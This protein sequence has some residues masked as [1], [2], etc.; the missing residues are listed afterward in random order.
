MSLLLD[1]ASNSIKRS[2]IIEFIFKLALCFEFLG[3]NSEISD[4]VLYAITIS[5]FVIIENKSKV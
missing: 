4:N 1:N 5:V 3:K 2:F